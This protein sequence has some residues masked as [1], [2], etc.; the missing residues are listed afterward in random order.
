M[1]IENPPFQRTI[2]GCNVVKTGIQSWKLRFA[3]KIPWI[4]IGIIEDNEQVLK[5]HA[6]N[7]DHW[8]GSGCFIFQRWIFHDVKTR[9]YCDYAEAEEQ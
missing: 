6:N 7:S 4:C 8:N 9:S 3:T 1:S 5:A 2:Y